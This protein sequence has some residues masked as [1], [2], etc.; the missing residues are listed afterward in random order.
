MEISRRPA[1]PADESIARELHERG[2]RDVVVRQF[3]SWN[4]EQQQ[5]FFAEKW[6][7]V[8]LKSCTTRSVKSERLRG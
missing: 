1:T 4:Q 2:Y 6:L 5:H 3:G 7:G 8:R